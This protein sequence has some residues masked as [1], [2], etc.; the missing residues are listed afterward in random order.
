MTDNINW[1][2]HDGSDKCPI[3]GAL[4]YITHYLGGF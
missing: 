4:L 2:T 3:P 1:M